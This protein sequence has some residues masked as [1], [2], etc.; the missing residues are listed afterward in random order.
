MKNRPVISRK[1]LP[2]RISPAAVLSYI[3]ALHYFNA[4]VW[5]WVII[6]SLILFSAIARIADL[7]REVQIEIFDDLNIPTPVKKEFKDK[8]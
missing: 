5:L 2:T 6:I 1:N 3:V 8:S 4:P 7:S